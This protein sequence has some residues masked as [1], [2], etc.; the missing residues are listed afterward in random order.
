MALI[1]SLS[2]TRR[3]RTLRL[4]TR[5]GHLCPVFRDCFPMLT[6]FDS[7]TFTVI[8][9]PAVWKFSTDLYYR[10]RI[11][12]LARLG[13]LAFP[14]AVHVA[15]YYRTGSIKCAPRKF[16]RR[17]CHN[18]RDVVFLS[19]VG[20]AVHVSISRPA[21]FESSQLPEK[22]GFVEQLDAPLL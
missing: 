18:D 4:V 8:S 22:F 11:R 7:T 15:Q 21:L 19:S 13:Q 10:V 1:A 5:Y 17:E 2:R 12:P 3:A 9:I 6:F 16:Q 20:S 14:R